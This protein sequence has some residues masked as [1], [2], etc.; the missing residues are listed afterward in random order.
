MKKIGFDIDGTFTDFEEFLLN[1]SKKYML[2]KYGLELVN[3]NGYDID[4]MFDIVNYYKSNGFTYEQALEK[5]NNIVSDFWNKFYIK[6]ALFSSMRKGIQPVIDYIKKSGHEV[7]IVSSRKRTCEYG[8]I[9]T[10]MRAT[11]K[12]QLLLNGI[13]YDHLILCENDEEKVQIINQIGIDIFVDDKPKILETL[14][15]N[16]NVIGMHSSYNEYIRE[17]DKISNIT[18][19]PEMLEIDIIKKLL[20]NRDF[21]DKMKK[22]ERTYKIVRSLARPFI[23]A[24]FNP[25]VLNQNNVPTDGAAVFSPNHRKTLDPFIIVATNK[26]AIHWAALK[27]FFD[28]KDSIFNNSKNP[29]LCK[30]TSFIFNSIGAIPIDR[31]NLNLESVKKMNEYLAEQTAIGIFPEGTTN[32]NPQVQEI[33]P[34]KPGAVRLAK[35]NNAWIVPVSIVWAINPKAKN[36]VVINYRTPFKVGSMS[37]EELEQ[38]WLETINDGIEE[39]ETVLNEIFLKE[40]KGYQKK[41]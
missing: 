9:G 39:N 3:P 23:K 29:F 1:N 34:I 4:E 12:L 21:Y 8:I 16:I 17:N 15:S 38:N 10:V 19:F 20:I 41:Y 36:K 33:L 14:S 6:Y 7:Y 18:N 40:K 32:K 11:V 37:I 30:L 35:R 28:S 22:N 26:R 24:V 31:D 13:K 25:I 5:S 27:R 2:K